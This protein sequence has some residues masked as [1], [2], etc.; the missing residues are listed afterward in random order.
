MD[1]MPRPLILFTHNWTHLPIDDLAAK[2]AEWGYSGFELS[3]W[4]DHLEI[5]RAIAEPDYCAT[6]LEMLARHDLQ[7]PVVSN[8]RVGQAVCDPI[9]ARHQAL[10]PDYVWG[11]GDPQGARQRAIEEMIAT[12]RVADKLGA[13]VVS[14]FTG[15]NLWSYVLGYPGPTAETVA[16]GFREFAHLWNPILDVAGECGVRFAFEVHP[17]QMA[18]DYHSAEM[19]LDALGDRP[20]F[21]FTFDPS[22]FHWQGIDPAEFVHRF[23]DRIYHVHVKDAVLNLNG[24]NGVLNG[25]AAP[26]DSRRGWHFRAP[27][28]GGVDWEAVIRALNAVGYSGALSVEFNDR[29]M[30]REFGAE[31]AA[32]FVRRLDFEPAAPPKPRAFR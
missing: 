4:G 13:S 17:G 30:D 22:H 14:G 7:A 25:Y 6:K 2:A 1:S 18:F 11:D 16:A 23:G 3:C 12:F 28:R 8:H 31:E 9:D 19:A 20:E 27:G 10:I 24:R 21:G 5:Q 26:G 32:K 29:D 15:S